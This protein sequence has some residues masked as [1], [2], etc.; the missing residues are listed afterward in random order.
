MGK[1]YVIVEGDGEVQAAP[2]LIRRILHEYFEYYELQNVESINAHSNDNITKHN[3]LET[4]LEHTRQK[5]DCVGVIVLLDAERTHYQC[6]VSLITNLSGRAKNL[7]LPFP[8]ALVC[9]CCEYESWFLGSIHSLEGKNYLNA[10]ISFEGNPEEKCNAK[11]WIND[12]IK[13]GFS[14]RE[15][16]DQVKMTALL[17]IHH[18]IENVRSFRRMVHAIEEIILAIENKMNTVTPVLELP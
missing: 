10:S 1:I 4:L 14:Y 12:N 11:E 8:V 15:T 6:V 16:R 13:E 3:G 2:L 7:G 5:S 18:L 9:A 17:D